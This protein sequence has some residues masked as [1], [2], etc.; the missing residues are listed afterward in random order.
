V[1]A[2]VKA[3]A[4]YY[5]AFRLAVNDGQKFTVQMATRKGWRAVGPV[6]YHPPYFLAAPRV[7]MR[8]GGGRRAKASFLRFRLEAT[9]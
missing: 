4:H 8:V 3:P 2:V 7:A 1:L 5:S 6:G 9:S